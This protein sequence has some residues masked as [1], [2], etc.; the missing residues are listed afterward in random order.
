MLRFVGKKVRDDVTNQFGVTLIPAGSLLDIEMIEL[1]DNHRIDLF[2]LKFLNPN[3]NLA[4]NFVDQAV[5]RS[6]E[7][8]ESIE[9]TG[10]VPLEEIQGEVIPLILQVSRHSNLFQ[11]F[12]SVKAVDEYTYQHNIGVGILSTL[13][14]RWLELSE[15]D[16]EVLSIAGTLHDV[17]KVYIPAEILNKPGKLTAEEYDLVKQHSWYGYELLSRIPDLD[18]RIPLAALQHHERNDGLGY[19]YGVKEHEIELFS[20]II[21]V[22]DIFHAMSSRR[23]YHEPRA[24]YQIVEQMRNGIFGLLDPLIVTLFLDRIMDKMV[25]EQVVLTDGQIGEVISLNPHQPLAPLVKVGSEFIDLSRRTDMH[26][27][28]IFISA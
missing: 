18:P 25:G 22:A 26:I 7:L 27:H 15:Q 13:I 11:L 28:S 10:E 14:G 23:S 4:I 5:L 8:F 1:L 20:K 24:F 2:N 16:L 9:L 19:P 21:A 3:P 12:E 6:K 17:G